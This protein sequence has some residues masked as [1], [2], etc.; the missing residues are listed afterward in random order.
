MRLRILHKVSNAPQL[1]IA[2]LSSMSVKKMTALFEKNREIQTLRELLPSV[3]RIEKW[4]PNDSLKAGRFA[5]GLEHL[6][7]IATSPNSDR[8]EDQDT[9]ASKV[10]NS[11]RIARAKPK[12]AETD[13][14]LSSQVSKLHL[15]PQTPP[16]KST[17]FQ[18]NSFDSPVPFASASTALS[19]PSPIGP[20]LQAAI[21]SLKREMFE[22]TGDEQTVNTCLVD[23]II[24][25]ASIL[26]YRGRVRLDRKPFQVLKKN[27]T[28]GKALYEACVDGFI[29]DKDGKGIQAIMEVKRGL[30]GGKPNV[31]MQE[32]A[33]MAAFVYSKGKTTE[34]SRYRDYFFSAFARH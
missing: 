29:L 27:A 7:I 31:R 18:T 1:S 32:G 21:D 17:F 12:P 34:A 30:R 4:T 26:K 14:S 33:Q 8:S 24:P 10:I 9:I 13:T 2:H 20:D 15:I 28:D 23:L 22:V 3:E 6:H 16:N 5:V 11:P 19:V 25:I